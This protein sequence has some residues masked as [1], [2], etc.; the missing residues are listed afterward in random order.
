MRIIFS[1]AV[2][3]LLLCPKTS[4]AQISTFEQGLL[5]WTGY[6]AEF[7][8]SERFQLDAEVDSRRFFSPAKQYQSVVRTTLYFKKSDQI[9]FGFG[10][11]YSALHS[12]YTNI[13]QPE[14]RPHQELNNSY[15]QGRWQFNHRLR[16][17]QRFVGD[18]TRTFLTN[19]EIVERNESGFG[20]TLRSRYELA[21]DFSVVNKDREKGHLNLQLKTEIMINDSLDELFN[22][23]RIHGGV[24]YFLTDWIRLELAY[25]KSTEK[26]HDFGTLFSYDNIRFTFRQRIK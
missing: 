21:A 22:T 10:I 4:S 2:L 3:F 17:E 7:H 12:L 13:V 11:A 24:Q 8:L 15:G 14:I 23:A 16:L 18:T 20:F 1:L 19:N 26:E 9:N 5:Y 6:Y 25:L